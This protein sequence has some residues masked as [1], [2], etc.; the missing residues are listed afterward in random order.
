MVAE[1]KPQT[2]ADVPVCL[3]AKCDG[4]SVL[5]EAPRMSH[6]EKHASHFPGS[7]SSASVLLNACGTPT[8]MLEQVAGGSSE[9]TLTTSAPG[10]R[11]VICCLALSL[12][13]YFLPQ[14][15]HLN[16]FFPKCSPSMWRCK[17]YFCLK[18]SWQMSQVKLSMVVRGGLPTFPP[19]S[20]G[21]YS[22]GFTPAP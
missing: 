8:V 3:H 14:P 20:L 15:V 11:R 5:V 12:R 9:A 6:A 21:P 22:S 16:G 18:D 10:Q 17:R 4:S 13:E 1:Y 2:N 19:L 7:H